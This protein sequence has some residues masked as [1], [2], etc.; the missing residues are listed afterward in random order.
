MACV[1]A[2][3]RDGMFRIERQTEMAS[4]YQRISRE[5]TTKFPHQA[6]NAEK[7]KKR[8]LDCRMRFRQWK[9]ITALSGVSCD[10]DGRVR[11]PVETFDTM[12][13]RY[14]TSKWLRFEALGDLP[15]YEEVF[16]KESALGEFQR[17]AGDD[18]DLPDS[19]IEDPETPTNR[20]PKRRRLASA[21]DD[22]GS[23]PAPRLALRSKAQQLF[24]DGL[25][26][27]AL[28][29]ATKAEGEE[30]VARAMDSVTA[31]RSEL[32]QQQLFAAMRRMKEPFEAMLFVKLERDE[33][34]AYLTQ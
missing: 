17:E 28:V 32:T 10:E 5:M 15:I 7:V 11:A 30:L 25:E 8:F 2:C 34:I 9:T 12:E 33:Q 26:R 21:D 13:Q 29:L 19:P 16:E 20:P 14:P 6:W 1:L 18:E 22:S 27:A 24:G 31:L 4:A 23:S 3:A